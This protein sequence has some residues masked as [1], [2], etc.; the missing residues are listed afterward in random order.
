MFRPNLRS[1]GH[2]PLRCCSPI[3]GFAI[4]L[5]IALP[6][7]R[8]REARNG[9]A[10]APRCLAGSA[11]EIT[12]R[13]TAPR[14][15]RSRSS[16]RSTLN[17]A[18]PTKADRR[19]ASTK[20]GATAGG[21]SAGGE[22]RHQAGRVKMTAR[23]PFRTSGPRICSGTAGYRSRYWG[24]E[25]ECNFAFTLSPYRQHALKDCTR[26]GSTRGPYSSPMSFDDRSADR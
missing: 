24:C 8:P 5:S 20:C 10:F 9:R 25:D 18:V 23:D 14:R 11:P 12:H 15:G 7:L 22:S 17:S 21:M 3:S 6:L 16:R 26:G 13:P 2:E 1:G 19:R 4:T